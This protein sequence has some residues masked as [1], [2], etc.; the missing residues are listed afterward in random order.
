MP[1]HA[2]A[3]QLS[4]GSSLPEA[5]AALASHTDGL[6]ILH[7][8]VPGRLRIRLPRLKGEPEAAAG[9]R[10]SLAAASGILAV[11]VSIVT[12]SVLILFDRQRPHDEIV[13][14]VRR[15]SGAK[16]APA[17]P[18]AWY[19]LEAADVLDQLGSSRK[20]GLNGPE[21]ARRLREQGANALPAMRGRS[22]LALVADQIL[23]LPVALLAGSAVVSIV[24]G[25]LADALVIGGVILLN[26]AIGYATESHA[27]R[28]IRALGEDPPPPARVLRDGRAVAVPA[29]EVV[30]GDI[31]LLEPGTIVAADARLLDA[32]RLSVDESQ[33]TG[34]SVPVTKGRAA[35]EVA[36][37]ALGDRRNMVFRGTAV[38]S[39]SG[40]AVVVETGAATE[41]GKVQVL[42]GSVAQPVTPLQRQLDGMGR[43]LVLLCGGVCVAIFGLG[44]LRGLGLV[45]MLKTAV[46]LAVAALPEGLPAIATS[47]LALGVGRMRRHKVLVRHLAAIE[48]LGSVQTLCFDKTGTLTLNRMAAR[49]AWLGA[50][51]LSLTDDPPERLARLLELMVLCN[52]VEVTRDGNGT[53]L[54]GSATEMALV[55][56][57]A[58]RG[59]DAE[60]VRARQ[61]TAQV[62]LRR[63]DRPLMV[64][65]HGEGSG[66]WLAAVKGS[67]AAVLGLCAEIMEE[68]GPAPLD[69]RHRQRVLAANEA[70]Q[71]EG[72]RVLGVAEGRFDSI[73]EIEGGLRWVGLVGLADPVRPGMA[74]LMRTFHAAGIKTVMITGDQSGTAYAI[75]RSLDL[76]GE[77]EIEILESSRLDQLERDVLDAM[78]PRTDVFARV[79]PTNKL[80]I[81]QAIQ[82]A[83]R[84]VAMTGDG[85][86]DGPAL[87]AANVGVAMG[88]GGTEVARSVA[89]IVLAE[90]DLA[91]MAA[92]VAQG[93][94][95]YG[96]IRKS[97]HYLLATNLSEIMVTGGG[98]ALGTGELVT[99]IQLLWLNLVSDV[100]P[101][102]ALALE[103]EEPDVMR[104]PPRDPEAPMLARADMLG[105]AREA[106][107]LSAGALGA[108][109]FGR[110]RHGA[111][112]IANS[113]VFHTLTASQLA[114]AWA[115]RSERHGLLSR[116]RLQTNPYLDA[117]LPVGVTL[118]AATLLIPPL[119]RLLGVTPLG[120]LDLA[121]VAAG[122]LAPLLANEAVKERGRKAA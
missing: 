71:Q 105:F 61:P 86:N 23:T 15:A 93:R 55:T 59:V 25:G 17:D 30:R 90:D 96:N 47:T 99:P 41:G 32:S 95:I 113:L 49:A 73:S 104:Q 75:A 72:L 80:Q 42:L 12:A 66:P 34:E 120:I 116:E 9:F 92:A 81:V 20:T 46:S 50:D 56:F 101:A 111:G 108:Y 89:D 10:D 64:T 5:T 3:A 122:A 4:E 118:Q 60:A 98:V 54:N 58:E 103:P 53:R 33:L 28:V 51:R 109:A 21:A 2:P 14:L 8:C 117:A 77:A 29:E 85:V 18:D 94:T 36:H 38:A 26:A 13:A 40:R 88:Q 27:E 67:P 69:E 35:I 82:H 102:L 7:A 97:I 76:A 39:G 91:T 62:E 74:E 37:V 100:F 83:G 11:E 112:P 52:E 119:R 1:G 68:D 24:T 106:A 48:T 31:L 110:W 70:A 19:R 84:V 43:R 121:V 57:A 22:E 44:L 6:I 87:K 63:E 45:P 78:A 65:W 107:F 114:H 16:P 115:C 79:S